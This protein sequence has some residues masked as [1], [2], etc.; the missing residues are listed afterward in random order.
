MISFLALMFFPLCMAYAAASDLL[1][2][3]IPNWLSIALVAGFI[4]FAL[5]AGMD[6]WNIGMHLVCALVVLAG[7]F[8]LFAAGWIGGGD[9]KI[10]AAIA[11]WFGWSHLVEFLVLSSILGGAL[12]LLILV[13]R[14]WPVPARLHGAEWGA[15]LHEP[16]QGVP[17]GI[18]F[19]AAALHLYPLTPIWL[20]L[21]PA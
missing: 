19:A 7:G 4:P 9:A 21:L 14:R 16:K 15:R 12:T 6:G 8:A 10:A 2:M 1:T 17:Y 5:A 13:W 3:R 20:R 18:A 11:V